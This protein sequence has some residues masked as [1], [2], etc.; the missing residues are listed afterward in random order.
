MSLMLALLLLS[1]LSA[2][3]EFD[4]DYTA[5]FNHYNEIGEMPDPA[6]K[7]S[8]YMDMLE[9][10][11]DDR[12]YEF[13]VGGSAGAIQETVNAGNFDAVYP[14]ADRYGE[15]YPDGLFTSQALGLDA[16][17][18]DGNSAMI[19]KYGEPVYGEMPNPQ[20][21]L[22]L[23]QAFGQLKN[24]SKMIHYARITIDSGAFPLSDI[25]NIAYTVLQYD[26]RE[27][28]TPDAVALARKIRSDVTS[29]PQGLSA[30][31]WNSVQVFMLDLIGRTDFEAKRYREA[32]ASFDEILELSPR[33][34]KAWYL[35]GNTMLQIGSRPNDAAL[36]LAKAVV[37][38]GNYAGQA[39][40]LLESIAAS[41]APPGASAV[42][43]YVQEKLG[44]ARREVGP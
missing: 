36:A 29:A 27:G 24:E 23:T 40:S 39:R 32:L 6:A 1:P 9:A 41:N 15:L 20:I 8:A 31:D 34:D 33:S 17:A 3:Q 42:D 28:Q 18:R 11:V 25:F 13:V 44:Q 38:D 26:V 21:A 12:L 5:Q 7:A 2:P 37:I 19:A 4:P 22:L 35:K 30:N 16:A 43:Q 10:G 14:L